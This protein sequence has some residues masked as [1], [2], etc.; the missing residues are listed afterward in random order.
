MPIGMFHPSMLRLFYALKEAIMAGNVFNGDNWAIDTA[1][2]AALFTDGIFIR[3]AVWA[4][5]AADNDLLVKNADGDVLCKTRAKV[6]AGATEDE[7]GR[8]RLEELE[9]FHRGIDV[10]TIDDGTLYIYLK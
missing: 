7:I 5:H 10:D 1:F 6:P 3:K 9:G 4:P 2:S 8:L